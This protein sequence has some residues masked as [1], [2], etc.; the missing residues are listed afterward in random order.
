MTRVVGQH[1]VAVGLLGVG[2]LRV[3]ADE[4]FPVENAVGAVG[5]DAVIEL[6]AFAMRLGV[7]H[8]GV[9][10]DQLL[11]P[12]QIKSVQDGFR[13]FAVEQRL[14]LVA[15]EARPGGDGMGSPMAVPLPAPPARWRRER[16]ARFRFAAGNVPP[17]RPARAPIPSP[18]W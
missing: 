17:A 2:F 9:M 13:P 4:N 15:G 18:R 7:V 11:V 8:D 3:L 6:V 14:D 12:P 5:Q 16:R 1:E 10:I